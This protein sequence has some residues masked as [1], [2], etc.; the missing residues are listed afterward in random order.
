LKT[1]EPALLLMYSGISNKL[2]KFIY[3]MMMEL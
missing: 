2:N 1:N 3:L